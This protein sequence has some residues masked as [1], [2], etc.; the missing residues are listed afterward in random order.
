M[1]LNEFA[2]D[3]LG[4]LQYK[5]GM[6]FID[7]NIE[8]LMEGI[9]T[10]CDLPDGFSGT[11]SHT[12]YVSYYHFLKHEYD[13]AYKYAN[14]SLS[15]AN[16]KG[17]LVDNRQIAKSQLLLASIKY[18]LNSQR[19]TLAIEPI[20]IVENV[21]KCTSNLYGEKSFYLISAYR[22]LIHMVD[23]SSG[24]TYRN[25]YQELVDIYRPQVDDIENKL[26]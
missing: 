18:S 7:V 5:N 3:L 24:A 4:K 22:H 11:L 10:R 8:W 9:E 25:K 6:S 17:A 2:I 1:E 23:A 20:Q 14:M 12:W 26:S 19:G 13:V 21:V 15:E 16:K